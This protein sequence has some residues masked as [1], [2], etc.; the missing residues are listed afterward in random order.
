MIPHAYRDFIYKLI[1]ATE[2]N[3][4]SWE[5]IDPKSFICRREKVTATISHYFND[6]TEKLYYYFNYHN[7][8]NGNKAGFGISSDDED[9]ETMDRLFDASNANAYNI[10]DELSDFFE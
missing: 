9:F 3:E 4:V 8:V 10:E 5:E 1:S 2:T 7:I 6:D